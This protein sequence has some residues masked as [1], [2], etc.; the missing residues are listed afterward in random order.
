MCRLGLP[1][2]DFLLAPKRGAPRLSQQLAQVSGQK[3]KREAWGL[4]AV[5]SEMSKN[6]I[7][8]LFCVSAA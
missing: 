2:L 3:E 5:S 8:L 7:T 6:G 1:G 4:K